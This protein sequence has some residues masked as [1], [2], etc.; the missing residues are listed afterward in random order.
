MPAIS[1]LISIQKHTYLFEVSK[2]FRSY[3]SGN[4]DED[5]ICVSQYYTQLPVHLY[6]LLQISFRNWCSFQFNDYDAVNDSVIFI[7][8]YCLKEILSLNQFPL[9]QLCR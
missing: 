5:Q 2:D 3:T 4:R 7:P 9:V 8:G 1:Q 6:A